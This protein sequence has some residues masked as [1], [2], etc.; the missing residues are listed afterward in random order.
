MKP[1]SEKTEQVKKV[2]PT[3]L[4]VPIVVL[5]AVLDYLSKRPY[6]EVFKLINSLQQDAKPV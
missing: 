1:G 3:E 5:D 4:A 6:V 2:T